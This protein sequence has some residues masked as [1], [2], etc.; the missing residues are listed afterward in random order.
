MQYRLA[1]PQLGILGVE[2]QTLAARAQR[3]LQV[4]GV[5][6]HAGDQGVD[7]PHDRVGRRRARQAALE[8]SERLGPLA[9]LDGAHAQVEQHKRIVGLLFQLALE[10]LDVA[11]ELARLAGRVDIAGMR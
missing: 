8:E 1:M 9:P 3:L 4:P 11:I 2:L 6:V 7:L 10:D 5:L